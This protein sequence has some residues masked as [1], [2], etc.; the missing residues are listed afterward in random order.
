MEKDKILEKI[1][2]IGIIEDEIERRSILAELNSDVNN[3]FTEL[4]TNKNTID[5]LNKNIQKNNSDMDKLREY[6]MEL[7]KR[8]PVDKTE[9]EKLK[10]NG[11][12]EEKSK[13]KFEDLF[14]EKGGIK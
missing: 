14:D 1:T 5:E 11:M 4:E 2:N 3:L 13:R 7:F 10:D 8:L 9:E 6:N 12:E